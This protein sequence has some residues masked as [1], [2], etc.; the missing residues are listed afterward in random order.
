MNEVLA[1]LGP[2]PE[3]EAMLGDKS[4]EFGLVLTNKWELNMSDES[5]IQVRQQNWNLFI[6]LCYRK[7]FFGVFEIFNFVH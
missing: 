1:A 2:V 3:D 5:N 6:R 7:Q 4:T